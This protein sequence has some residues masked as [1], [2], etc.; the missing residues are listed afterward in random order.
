MWE[1]TMVVLVRLD[2]DKVQ[3][4][5]LEKYIMSGVISIADA[6]QS[7]AVLRMD[8]YQRLVWE[9]NMRHQLGEGVVAA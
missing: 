7:G 2:L 8:D 1:K 6:R 4:Q 3:L 5:Q 9:R